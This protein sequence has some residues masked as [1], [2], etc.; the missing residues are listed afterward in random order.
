MSVSLLDHSSVQTTTER[1]L[2]ELALA[3]AYWSLTSRVLT[4]DSPA[5]SDS[6]L[7]SSSA[8][9]A[10]RAESGR[11]RRRCAARGMLVTG[12]GARD[13]RTSFFSKGDIGILLVR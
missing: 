5:L 1:P 13:D 8:S 10:G 7:R 12:F 6:R 2:A 11:R 3:E 9:H 4:C